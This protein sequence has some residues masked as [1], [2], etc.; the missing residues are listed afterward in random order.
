[1][2]PSF[3]VNVLYAILG[4]GLFGC[5]ML[6]SH[7]K[8]PTELVASA[9]FALAIFTLG[10]IGVIHAIIR[11]EKAVRGESIDEQKEDNQKGDVK[12]TK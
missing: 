9:A 5:L 3:I 12:E 6:A 8:L 11:V 10:F 4:V 2:M 1:M 7:T